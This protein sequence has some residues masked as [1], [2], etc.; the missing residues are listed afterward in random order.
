MPPRFET[1]GRIMPALYQRDVSSQEP[2]Y[3]PWDR[4][5]SVLELKY[6]RTCLSI[7]A[8]LHSKSSSYRESCKQ[9]GNLKQFIH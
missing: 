9:T 7:G 3:P 4:I 1:I 8:M 5:K 2:R 6:T